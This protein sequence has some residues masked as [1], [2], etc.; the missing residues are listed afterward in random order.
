MFLV[1]QS[2]AITSSN[3]GRIVELYWS[4]QSGARSQ[5]KSILDINKVHFR[6]KIMRAPNVQP[7]VTFLDV[8]AQQLVRDPET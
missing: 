7:D 3:S 1:K 4:M 2:E 5:T 6:G 8:G